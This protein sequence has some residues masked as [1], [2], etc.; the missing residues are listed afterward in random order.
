MASMVA[1]ANAVLA[2]ALVALALVNA[3]GTPAPVAQAAGAVIGIGLLTATLIYERRR[4]AR[5]APG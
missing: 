4:I 2:G 1:A 5:A 3:I